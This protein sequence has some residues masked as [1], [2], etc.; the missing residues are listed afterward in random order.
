[1]T[2]QRTTGGSSMRIGYR[3]TSK[4]YSVHPLAHFKLG[5]TSLLLVRESDYYCGFRFIYI[6]LSFTIVN[7][8]SSYCRAALF[9]VVT[10]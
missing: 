10:V 6:D 5:V 2:G 3:M 9:Y 8:V 1:M 4:Y 7:V